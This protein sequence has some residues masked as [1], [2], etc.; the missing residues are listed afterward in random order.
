[1]RLQGSAVHADSP[2]DQG[3]WLALVVFAFTSRVVGPI[4]DE[5]ILSSR[6]LPDLVASTIL[7]QRNKAAWAKDGMRAAANVPFHLVQDWRRPA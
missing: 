5:V 3:G 6:V 2:F 4:A 1:M 7:N